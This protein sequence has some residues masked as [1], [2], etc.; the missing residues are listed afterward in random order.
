MNIEDLNDGLDRCFTATW[1]CVDIIAFLLLGIRDE[2]I[3][4][5]DSAK[6]VDLKTP[7]LRN[8]NLRDFTQ[9][10]LV[11]F[12]KRMLWC[13]YSYDTITNKIAIII[14]NINHAPKQ[15][16]LN[17]KQIKNINS[18]ALL[19]LLEHDVIYTL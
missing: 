4:R 1:T 11:C 3:A 7:Y 2:R 12:I 14:I 13:V 8:S 9:M 18:F 5:L 15:S 6:F 19:S 16:K 17:P 10:A